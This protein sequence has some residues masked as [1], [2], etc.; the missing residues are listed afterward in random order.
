MMELS[1]FLD[2][3]LK[4]RIRLT[5][6]NGL[7]KLQILNIYSRIIQS[8]SMILKIDIAKCSFPD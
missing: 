2:D 5:M 1:V 8:S 3:Q 4:K 7:S 6:C